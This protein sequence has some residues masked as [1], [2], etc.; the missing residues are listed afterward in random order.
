[1]NR[2]DKL[3]LVVCALCVAA[4]LLVIVLEP[5]KPK[6]P[7]TPAEWRKEVDATISKLERL[8]NPPWE[9][10]GPPPD[11]TPIFHEP[12]ERDPYARYRAHAV[13]NLD[14]TPRC[15][16]CDAE[17]FKQIDGRNARYCYDCGT[18]F[19]G[20]IVVEDSKRQSEK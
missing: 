11:P 13:M 19:G 16:N 5:F 2:G 1:M 14:G 10:D 4:L 7:S 17:W 12:G 20:M 6:A 18:E 15:A 9:G 3:A 8:F